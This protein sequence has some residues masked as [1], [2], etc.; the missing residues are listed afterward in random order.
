M[1]WTRAQGRWHSFFAPPDIRTTFKFRLSK[2][3]E[4]CV[5]PAPTPAPRVSIRR[6]VM[7]HTRRIARAAVSVLAVALC[8]ATAPAP[9]VRA[10]SA[11]AKLDADR[12]LQDYKLITLD[13]GASLAKVREGQ[14]LSIEAGLDRYD[15]DL[16]VNDL[17]AP[18]FRVEETLED[19]TTR[20]MPDT[21]VNTYRGA[22][23]NRDGAT[24]RFT[25]DEGRLSGLI[26]DGDDRVFV[27][28]LETY[29]LAG[30]PTD[31]LVYHAYDVRPEATPGTCGVTEAEKVSTAVEGLS[32]DVD[33]ASATALSTVQIATETDNEYVNAL[34]GAAAANSDIMTIVNQ[35][36]G[37]YQA[38]LGLAF[39]VVLQNTYAGADP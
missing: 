30:G 5:R 25:M 17:R 38:E 37:V 15:V 6:T 29:S 24:A 28:P 19:G 3:E 20:R 11:P 39:Q 34:G 31:Y 13:P 18:D 8:L 32:E 16:V 22:V 9:V 7:I 21:P 36:D 12:Y 14:T 26:I 4:P 2:P 35:I 33:K 10:V 1:F 27:E 23:T